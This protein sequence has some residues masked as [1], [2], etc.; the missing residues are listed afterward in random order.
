V[1]NREP[2]ARVIRA[3]RV[4]ARVNG[5]VLH[6]AARAKLILVRLVTVIVTGTVLHAANASVPV[7]PVILP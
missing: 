2:G 6:F 3:L 1:R 7:E 5:T 4:T